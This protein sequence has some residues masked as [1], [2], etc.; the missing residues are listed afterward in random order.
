MPDLQP[1]ADKP[2]YAGAQFKKIKQEIQSLA[3]KPTVPDKIR[4]ALKVYAQSVAMPEGSAEI[5]GPLD[6]QVDLFR[7]ISY[8]IEEL[9]KDR[10][11]QNQL[12]KALKEAAKS[13]G[14]AGDGSPPPYIQTYTASRPD[15]A[16]V[17]GQPAPPIIKAGE[18]ALLSE[19]LL[20][21][22]R[23]LAEKE[24][25]LQHKEMALQSMHAKVEQLLEQSKRE[26]QLKQMEDPLYSLKQNNVEDLEAFNQLDQRLKG[27]CEDLI[28]IQEYEVEAQ[29][30]PFVRRAQLEARI[31]AAA[32]EE[33]LKRI[34]ELR[35]I[36]KEKMDRMALAIE[37]EKQRVDQLA[38]E[39]ALKFY[40]EE[41]E[42]ERQLRRQPENPHNHLGNSNKTGSP[43]RSHNKSQVSHLGVSNSSVVQSDY[44]ESREQISSISWTTYRTNK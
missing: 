22:E 24:L 11:K 27:F 25:Q 3:M 15:R 28:A 8:Q 17:K 44:S 37:K 40:Q 23:E 20:R 10:E 12:E 30:D 41:Q 34:A 7:Q 33:K 2:T 39:M 18:P 19:A 26:A 16:D 13:R 4:D 43:D 9:T 14:L 29:A 31:E 5:S 35:R 21:K 36:E 38:K 32:E 42:L 1:K 6:R